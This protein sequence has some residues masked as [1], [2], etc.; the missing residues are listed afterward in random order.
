[1]PSGIAKREVAV[2]AEATRDE[3]PRPPALG[4]SLL[5]R[6]SF[7]PTNVR[8]YSNSGQIWAR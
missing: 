5:T 6:S 2:N 3:R 8:C 1:M 4:Q 7:G